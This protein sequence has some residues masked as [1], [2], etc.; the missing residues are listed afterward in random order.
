MKYFFWNTNK[1]HI[2][3]YVSDL[4]IENDYD[5][6]VLAE[7]ED[8]LKELLDYLSLNNIEMYN[9]LTPGC[10][11][12][13]II[14]KKNHLSVSSGVEKEYY[15]IKILNLK[16]DQKQI[17]ATVH[18]PSKLWA[19]DDDRRIEIAKL[20]KDIEYYEKKYATK[21]TVIMGDFNANP[22]EN[23]MTSASGL[24]AVSSSKVA[25]RGFRTIRKET[26]NMFYNP[27]WNQFGD[28]KGVAGTYYYGGSTSV[29]I[30]WNVFDQ[31]IIR[32]QIINLFEKQNLKIVTKSNGKM[33]INNNIIISD[34]LPIEFVIRED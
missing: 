27:M 21:N 9:I 1:N 28:F 20:V 15:A 14:A 22:F 29:E 3:Q 33:L 7:Y 17:M 6:I 32:P 4:I 13:T 11:R 25:S 5:I 10:K 30:F 23:C 16:Y 18:L 26:Y 24:H 8:N 2:N 12:I 31:V 34:H 19:G